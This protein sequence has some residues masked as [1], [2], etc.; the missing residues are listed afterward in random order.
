MKRVAY[1]LLISLLASGCGS[2][3]SN[4]S[5]QDVRYE[6]EVTEGWQ[7]GDSLRVRYVTGYRPEENIQ[8]GEIEIVS[9][10]QLSATASIDLSLAGES[11]LN[12]ENT[13]VCIEAEVL[14]NDSY[15]LRMAVRGAGRSIEFETDELT[16]FDLWEACLP[17]EGNE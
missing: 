4:D 5:K 3:G 7:E 15:R 11:D 10:P 14:E 2:S 12:S 17:K 6:V 8:E 16:D 1:L 9:E 13:D